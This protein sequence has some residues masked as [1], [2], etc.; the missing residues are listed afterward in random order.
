[1]FHFLVK[2]SFKFN[3]GPTVYFS[4]NFQA[5]VLRKRIQ[6]LLQFT[7]ILQNQNFLAIK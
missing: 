2:S 1:M 4:I 3:K 7:G 5:Y 6:S